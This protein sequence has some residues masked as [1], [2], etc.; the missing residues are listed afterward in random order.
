M[1]PKSKSKTTTFANAQE[2]NFDALQCNLPVL[3]QGCSACF[4]F[5][6]GLFLSSISYSEE[7]AQPE[8]EAKVE[9]KEQEQRKVMSALVGKIEGGQVSSVMFISMDINSFCFFINYLCDN[10]KN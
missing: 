9:I 4:K 7:V 1:Y 5:M 3:P 8:P 2:S 6:F 10:G